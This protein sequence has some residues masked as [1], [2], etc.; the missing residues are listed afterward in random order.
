MPMEEEAGIASIVAAVLEIIILLFSNLTGP[1]LASKTNT[2][3]V[4]SPDLCNSTSRATPSFSF[5]FPD[6]H[7]VSRLSI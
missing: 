2:L 1:P 4:F 7:P 3:N 6:D 5:I